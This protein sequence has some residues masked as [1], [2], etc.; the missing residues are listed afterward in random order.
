MSKADRVAVLVG[1]ALVIGG[2]AQVHVPSA[3]ALAGV[4]LLA[5]VFWRPR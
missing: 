1:F 5:G 2:V 4:L 3:T